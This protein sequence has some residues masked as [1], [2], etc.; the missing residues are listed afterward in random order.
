LSQPKA[1]SFRILDIRQPSLGAARVLGEALMLP[2]LF[3]VSFAIAAFKKIPAFT[4]EWGQYQLR[5]ATDAHTTGSRAR[6]ATLAMNAPPLITRTKLQNHLED[7]QN[8]SALYPSM[9]WTNANNSGV[10]G[11]TR[12]TSKRL[13]AA[14]LAAASAVEYCGFNLCED[15]WAPPSRVA[16]P[17]STNRCT[18]EQV[19]LL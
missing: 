1:H 14:D 16:P 3:V 4:V 19:M 11:L 10:K 9:I 18:T 2:S 6:T 12:N 7:F 15:G 5:S 8:R 17:W 13:V